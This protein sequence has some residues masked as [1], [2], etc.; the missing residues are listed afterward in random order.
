MT[1]TFTKLVSAI[2][3]GLGGCG[4]PVVQPEAGR[5]RF[6]LDSGGT[7]SVEARLEE[8]WL[9]MQV[10]LD[11]PGDRSSWSLLRGNADLP[12]LTRVV[13]AEPGGS[14]ILLVEIPLGRDIDLEARLG[15]AC[16]GLSTGLALIAGD[17][18]RNRRG[19]APPEPSG[20][21]SGEKHDLSGLL[22]ELAPS[23]TERA[24]GTRVVDIGVARGPYRAE[25]TDLGTGG[26]RL[27]VPLGNVEELTDESR[28]AL[29]PFLLGASARVRM[30]RSAVEESGDTTVPRLETRLPAS[31]LPAEIEGALA[32]LA[33]GC[34]LFGPETEA[35]LERGTAAQYLL[36]RGQ[37]PQS[38]IPA[39]AARAG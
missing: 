29:G 7:H 16:H 28:D 2:T 4:L 21:K 38:R 35:L 23:F 5:W 32:A 36:V 11:A 3:A 8:G 37:V 24:D 13:L 1:G 6:A 33:A 34:E 18:K 19:G 39:L 12:P 30:A 25:I 22:Q 27:A 10:R 15:S 20:E 26:L 9:T 14:P 31:P 17:K